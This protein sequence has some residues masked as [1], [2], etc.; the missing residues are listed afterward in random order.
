MQQPVADIYS[1]S[2][3][4]T[5]QALRRTSNKNYLKAEV[6]LKRGIWLY[7]WL[8]LFEGAL[9]KWVLP[10]LSAPLLIV[11]DPI[12]IWLLLYAYQKN[13]FKINAYIG[14]ACA[15]TTISVV[16]TLLLGHGNFFVAL[17]GARIFLVHFPLMF[18]IG[19]VF[20][21]ADV[22]KM[23][24]AMLWVSIPMTVL[25]GFQFY[26]PQSAWVN[27]GVGGDT[28]GAGFFGVNGYFRPPGTFSF[29]IG[30]AAY[31]SMT[32]AYIFYF[33]IGG[34]K[35]VSRVL[36]LLATGCLLAAI[37]FSIS[38]T[39][40]FAAGLSGV[41]ALLIPLVRPGYLPRVAGAVVGGAVLMYVLIQLGVFSASLDAMTT[42]FDQASS[43]EGGVVKGT[44]GN[45]VVGGFLQPFI[46]SGNFPFWGV[47]IGMG[48]NA[49]A[50][51]L[52]GK[53]QFMVS[54]A[55]W[56]RLTGE[57]GLVLGLILIFIRVSI[58]WRLTT[59]S[60]RQI[61]LNNFLPWLLLSF[62]FINILQGQWAQPTMLGFSTLSGGLVIAAMPRK[63]KP[64]Q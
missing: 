18:L 27:R 26:S 53:A 21:Q 5:E 51:M 7:F 48:T 2:D 59:V 4:L 35:Q 47:G 41:F 44:V 61:K 45:R 31:Y 50:Q 39:L 8:L 6:L 25:M 42:R 43:I 20:T 37:P 14:I 22:I 24:K 13:R 34:T 11:R 30:L 62:A 40:L 1:Y 38:R 3:H 36:L 55:E 16:T 28:A 52:T 56:G 33:W 17:Y 32:A 12:A 23:G 29:I 58:V 57:M 19:T 9:R 64:N 63:A 15:V 60:F 54:E 10:D 46:E 49:G